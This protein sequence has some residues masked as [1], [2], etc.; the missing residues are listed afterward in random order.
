MVTLRLFHC[1]VRT[2]G[3][4]VPQRE[5]SGKDQQQ[6]KKKKKKKRH[7]A[8]PSHYFPVFSPSRANP[9]HP[10]PLSYAATTPLAKCFAPLW[11][12]RRRQNL[13]DRHLGVFV[14]RRGF[15]GAGVLLS[16]R[17]AQVL[18]RRRGAAARSTHGFPALLFGH[19]TLRHV[20]L[21]D[22]SCWRER[23]TTRQTVMMNLVAPLSS[24]EGGFLILR[25]R[26]HRN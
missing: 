4:L 16:G 21:R 2:R 9:T 20:L 5:R 11:H 8:L 24:F 25:G 7:L 6:R 26:S 23:T 12:D 10:P 1:A 19:A 22:L 13:Q 17:A 3:P 18:G 15:V 14:H